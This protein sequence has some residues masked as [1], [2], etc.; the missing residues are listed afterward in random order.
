MLYMDSHENSVLSE[1]GAGLGNSR[2]SYRVHYNEE[3]LV[4][5]MQ[6]LYIQIYGLQKNM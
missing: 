1:G 6:L 5:Y 3:G 4:N 2:I